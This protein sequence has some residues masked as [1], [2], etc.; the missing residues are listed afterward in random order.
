MCLCTAFL[1]AVVSANLVQSESAESSC[2][3]SE[4]TFGKNL[5]QANISSGQKAVQI[6]PQK[7]NLKLRKSMFSIQFK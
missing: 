7:A 5:R 2:T 1:V 6:Y 3:S 4:L